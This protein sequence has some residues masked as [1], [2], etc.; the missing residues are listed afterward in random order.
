V[1]A[2]VCAGLSQVG[3]VTATT[4]LSLLPV[5]GADHVR[6]I[7]GGMFND[8]ISCMFSALAGSMPMTTFAQVGQPGSTQ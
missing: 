6:R 5:E 4:E 2:R 8:A 3:D 7:R 1:L